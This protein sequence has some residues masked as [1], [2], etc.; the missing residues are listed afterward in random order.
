MINE[1][2][3]MPKTSMKN[4]MKSKLMNSILMAIALIICSLI[5]IYFHQKLVIN[6]SI[7][8]ILAISV[9]MINIELKKAKGLKVLNITMAEMKKGK[10]VE[11]D[12][13]Y[14]NDKTE[15]GKMSTILNNTIITINNM[16]EEIKRN[17]GDIDAQTI[18][19]TYISE[20]MLDLTSNIVK[21]TEGVALATKNQ[22][23]NISNIVEQLTEFGENING[24]NH[25]IIGINNLSNEIGKKS[26]NGNAELKELSTGGCIKINLILADKKSGFINLNPLF[27]A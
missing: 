12:E 24:V 25:S 4:N 11:I 10:F 9:V 2:N 18:G 5:F 3:I 21:S 23:E 20:D 7:I 26:E 19:L 16:L 27:C 14:L 17:S 8:I 1:S 15:I 13:K 6:I 22:T